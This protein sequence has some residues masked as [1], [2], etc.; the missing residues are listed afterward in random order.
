MVESLSKGRKKRQF[1]LG[2]GVS[3]VAT[4]SKV[5]CCEL[6]GRQSREQLPLLAEWQGCGED[7]DTPPP[8]QQ[9]ALGTPCL[10]GS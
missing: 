9:C 2:V 4:E 1:N 3:E 10:P 7:G 5:H 6:R 8:P